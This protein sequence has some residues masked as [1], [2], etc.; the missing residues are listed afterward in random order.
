MGKL[1]LLVVLGIGYVLGAR[2]GRAR[3]E[4]IKSRAQQ[5]AQNPTVRKTASQ[6]Q[7]TVREQAPVVASK[8]GD[9]AGAAAQKV[10][11]S[12]TTEGSGPE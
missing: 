11:P 9:V 2:A 7:Q 3:Y 12:G 5:F 6:A 1:K 4:Q 8:V 10:K